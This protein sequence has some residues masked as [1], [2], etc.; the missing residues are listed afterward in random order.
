MDIKVIDKFN[1]IV[2]IFGLIYMS[3]NYDELMEVSIKELNNRGINGELFIKKNFK[4]IDRYIKTFSKYKKVDDKEIFLFDKED[5]CIYILIAFVLVSNEKL[6]DDLDSISDEELKSNIIDLYNDIFEENRTV[7]SINTL[8]STMNFLKEVDV[9]EDTK[10]KLMIVLNNPREYY[11]SLIKVIKNNQKAYEEAYKSI[12]KQ[13]PKIMNNYIR[14]IESNECDVLSN[15][16]GPNNLSVSVIPSLAFGVM[17]IEIKNNYFMGIL[18]ELIYKEY[19]NS[20]GN[21]GDVVLKLKALGDKSKL[22]I[23]SILKQGPKYSLEI[24]DILK[25]TPATVSYHMSMLLEFNMV[26]IE[27]K[28]GKIYYHLNKESL[29]EFVNELNNILL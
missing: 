17:L 16:I 8:D 27:K 29:K 1:P 25:L 28:Q 11:K 19:V 5:I 21:K 18:Y 9:A 7:E 22:E 4:I 13:L 12:E 20:M 14:Y 24:A 26:S 10:W 23:I 2:E 6:I 3:Q 15:M